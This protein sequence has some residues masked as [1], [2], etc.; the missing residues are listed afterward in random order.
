MHGSKPEC[1]H[2]FRSGLVQAR[3]NRE[4]NPA[5]SYNRKEE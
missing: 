3:F 2:A 4:R 1:R 5:S